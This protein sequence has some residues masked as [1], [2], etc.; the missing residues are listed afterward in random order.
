MIAIN[1]TNPYDVVILGGGLAGLTLTKQ[2]LM[3]RPDTRIA[4]LEKRQFPVTEATHKVG[5]SSVEI[6]AHYFGEQLQLKKHL[7]DHQLPK[8]GL[9]F[10]FK[11]AFQ[12]LAEGTEVGGSTFF[13]APSYQLD[14]GRFENF[15]AESVSQMGATVLSGA[16]FQ[17]V[18]LESASEEAGTALS[19]SCIPAIRAAA[20]DLQSLGRRC[21]RTRLHFEAQARSGRGYWPRHQR[22]MVPDRCQYSD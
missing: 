13:S 11:D 4:V 6:G 8:F 10:F 21:E 18:H 22:G 9:R 5:E 12:T 1:Q 15:L 2:L 17:E 3:K 14:R 20:R 19:S 7:T 16:R